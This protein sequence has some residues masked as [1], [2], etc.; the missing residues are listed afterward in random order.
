MSFSK[1]WGVFEKPLFWVNLKKKPSQ[2]SIK[3]PVLLPCN[4]PFFLFSPVKP[5]P[6]RFLGP[7]SKNA[8]NTSPLYFLSRWGGGELAFFLF[9][10]PKPPLPQLFVRPFFLGAP[11]SLKKKKKIGPKF[12]L[13]PL[14]KTQYCLPIRAKDYWG[15]KP[16]EKAK[17]GGKTLPSKPKNNI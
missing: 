14:G 5:N 11:M 2:K 17:K 8:K 9:F 16:K 6:P 15:R 7:K 13:S 12:K 4:K 1:F 3:F 10:S